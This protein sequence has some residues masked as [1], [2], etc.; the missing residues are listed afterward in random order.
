MKKKILGLVTIAI[1]LLSSCSDFLDEVAYDKFQKEDALSNP[2][3]VYINSVAAI[4]S[5]MGLQGTCFEFRTYPY[6]FLSEFTSDLAMLPGRQGDWV[7]GGFHQNAFLHSWSPSYA[8]FLATWNDIYKQI[9]LCNSAYEDLQDMI[10]KGGEDYL[11]DYQY[12]IR[13]CRAFYYYHAIN[14]FGRVPIIVSSDTKVA[15]VKQPNRTQV[16]DFLRDELTD[17]IP[18]LP[19]AKSADSNSQY[20]GRIT[21]AVGYMMMAKLAINAPIFSEEDWN[22]GSFTGGINAVESYITNAGK[23]ITIT[24]E[25]TTRNAWETVIYCKQRIKELGYALADNFKS[26]FLVGNEGSIENIFIRPNDTDTYRLSQNLHW[27]SLHYAHS[28]A[29]GFNGGNGPIATIEA[30]KIFGATYDEATETADYSATD[31]RWDMSFFYGDVYVDGKR[32]A[33]QVSESYNPYGTYL[34]FQ[35]RIDYDVTSYSDPKGLYIVKWAGA[36]VKKLELDKTDKNTMWAHYTNA[37]F[38]VYR[39]ADALLLAAEAQ[40]RLGNISEALTLVN[41]VRN[42]VNAQ[43][44]ETLTLQDLLDERALELMWEPV[45]RE[46]QIRF[47]TYTEATDDKYPGV[48]HAN[49]AGDWVYDANGYTTVFPIPIDVLNLNKNLTQNPGY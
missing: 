29:M 38:V 3:L 27:Y 34:P 39:Y 6:S 43:P 7:D 8:A 12:E 19:E 24:L 26:N 42:R 28:A 10:D 20:Y 4:Y 46:D 14:L 23:N 36:R 30:V 47:G 48:P 18:H 41:E 33:S 31:P 16:Y 11:K 37:D 49:S 2:T 1:L 17:I 32:I 25:G 13:A 35:A 9:S 44:R 21:K 45:R 40:Y 5:G 15:D 22:D